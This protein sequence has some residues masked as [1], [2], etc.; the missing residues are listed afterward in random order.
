MIYVLYH[1][2]CQDGFCAAWVARKKL[3][4]TGVKYIPVSYGEPPPSEIIGSPVYILDFSYKR[5]VMEQL[6]QDCNVTVL[7]HH[8]TAEAELAGLPGCQFDMKRS[9]CMMTW[10]YFFPRAKT[11]WLVEYCQDRDLWRHQLPYTHEI[12]AYTSSW[13]S[14]FE[15]WDAL[16]LEISHIEVAQGAGILRYRQQLVDTALKNTKRCIIGGFNVPCVHTTVLFSEIAGTLAEKE[17]FGAAWFVKADGMI[18]F[19]LR[20]RGEFSVSDVAK[21]YGG[22]GHKNASGFQVTYEQ[23]E[24]MVVR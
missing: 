17:T 21:Q 16:P 13:P 24:R 23:F 19:S 22:G 18:Q 5:P 8:E 2:N 10:D 20:S 6:I 4:M 7:D 14:D 1:A 9:G 12:H 11:P 3:G 15:S